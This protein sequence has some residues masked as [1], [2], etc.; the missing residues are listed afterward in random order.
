M[1]PV[2]YENGIFSYGEPGASSSCILCDYV[3]NPLRNKLQAAYLGEASN[4][5]E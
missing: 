5:D 2:C 4:I 3:G 1:Q